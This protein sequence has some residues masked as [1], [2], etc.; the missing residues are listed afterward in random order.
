MQFHK[1][2]ELAQLT[3]SQV[4]KARYYLLTHNDDPVHKYDRAIGYQRADW[5]PSD[6]AKH[7]AGVPKNERWIPGVSMIQTLIDTA[8]ATQGTGGKPEAIGHDYRADLPA[9]VR[10]AYGHADV[11]DAQLARITTRVM[12][13]DE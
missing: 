1:P 5:L 3:P 9:T 6:S 11:T 12:K 8:T 7:P 13:R 2:N 10:V 4:D